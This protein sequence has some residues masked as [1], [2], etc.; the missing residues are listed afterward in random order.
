MTTDVL[1]DRAQLDQTKHLPK[2]QMR[3]DQAKISATAVQFRNDRATGAMAGQIHQRHRNDGDRGME[4]NE[5]AE[6]SVTFRR[7]APV[8]RAVRV[9]KTGRGFDTRDIQQPRM[10]WLLFVGFLKDK[11]VEPVAP[12]LLRQHLQ[13]P[14]R[15]NLP[16]IAPAPMDIPRDTREITHIAT[17][18]PFALSHKAQNA[19]NALRTYNVCC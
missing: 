12:N 7:P 8:L 14:G 18:A 13:G 15:I 9:D 10:R 4:E 5:V 11:R 2:R 1:A 16:V 6:K 17:C 3:G 19:L